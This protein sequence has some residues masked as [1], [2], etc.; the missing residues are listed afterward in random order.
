[1]DPTVTFEMMMNYLCEITRC[2]A[3]VTLPE[4]AT[5][6]AYHSSLPALVQRKE[7][8]RHL[9]GLQKRRTGV[10]MG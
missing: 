8:G 7:L 5:K 6:L 10:E 1:M 2:D 4:C 9:L 3:R